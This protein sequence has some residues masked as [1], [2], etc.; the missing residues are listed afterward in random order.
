MKNLIYKLIQ[1]PLH[2]TQVNYFHIKNFLNYTKQTANPNFP[3]S[4]AI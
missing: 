1:D 3:N 4:K 2:H